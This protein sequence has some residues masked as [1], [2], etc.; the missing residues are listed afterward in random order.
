MMNTNVAIRGCG[1]AVHA[2]LIV[3]YIFYFDFRNVPPAVIGIG[4]NVAF[5][6]MHVRACFHYWG[7]Y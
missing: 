3:F 1:A 4:L 5:I 6:V 2:S 7:K